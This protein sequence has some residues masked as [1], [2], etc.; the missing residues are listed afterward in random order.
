VNRGALL[1]IPA[2]LAVL[3]AQPSFGSFLSSLF[4]LVMGLA[5]RGWA[6]AHLGGAGRTRSAE[7]PEA[8]VVTGPYARLRHPL[9]VANL[10][11]SLGLVLALR[12]PGPI[13]VLL[14]LSVTAFYA[15]LAERE[16]HLLE[17]LPI[18]PP[19]P[20]LPWALVARHERSTWISL[21][22]ILILGAL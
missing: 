5:L 15:L 8:R 19:V 20:A 2:I 21:G 18:R 13:V 10:G 14:V 11:I 1:A 17:G 4:L 7:P 9:Y 6:T 3:S 12:P 16:N 22:L